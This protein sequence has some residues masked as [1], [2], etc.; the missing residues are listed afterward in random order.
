MCCRRLFTSNNFA[1]S[2]ALAEVF[3]LLSAILV[4]KEFYREIYVRLWHI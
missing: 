3:A 1:A 2:A 4:S